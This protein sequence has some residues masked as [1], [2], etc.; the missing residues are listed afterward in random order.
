MNG[1]QSQA[2]FLANTKLHIQ[3]Y[4]ELFI[5]IL[6]REEKIAQAWATFRVKVYTLSLLCSGN[7]KGGS[8]TVLLTSCLTG[9]D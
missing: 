5:I 3:T 6:Q 1:M 8:I 4:S 9:L 2:L 7:T